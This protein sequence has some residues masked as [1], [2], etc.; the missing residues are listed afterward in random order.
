[1]RDRVQPNVATRVYWRNLWSEGAGLNRTNPSSQ[2]PMRRAFSYRALGTMGFLA[3]NIMSY[4]WKCATIDRWL[5]AGESTL[6]EWV[7]CLDSFGS[8]CRAERRD[9]IIPAYLRPLKQLALPRRQR[10]PQSF[11]LNVSALLIHWDISSS[12]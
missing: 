2:H 9:L 5:S 1:M 4:W 8:L 11:S 10:G 7:N 12:Y 3:D 6:Q